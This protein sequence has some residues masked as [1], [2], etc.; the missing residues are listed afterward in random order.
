MPSQ[1]PSNSQRP[2]SGPSLIPSEAPSL[3]PSQSAAPSEA[4]Q[5]S[6]SP[7]I[8][9]EPSAVPTGSPV[10]SLHLEGAVEL[11]DTDL[12]TLT[13]EETALFVELFE[14]AI[15]SFANSASDDVIEST[16][17][18]TSIEGIGDRRRRN[19]QGSDED[20][21]T[22]N[23]SLD[24][25]TTCTSGCLDNGDATK[26]AVDGSVSDGIEDALVDEIL[27]ASTSD[28]VNNALSLTTAFAASIEAEESPSTAD[29]ESDNGPT[30]ETEQEQDEAPSASVAESDNGLSIE[31]QEQVEISINESTDTALAAEFY[32]D[33]IGHSGTCRNDG[34][35]P[36]YMTL[37]QG[38]IESS[39]QDCC[40][41]HF[42]FDMA[43]C[44]G[45]SADVFDR[46]FPDW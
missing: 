36:L 21:V 35:A 8:S 13:Q 32:P 30:I 14:G 5:P 9:F 31:T 26:L 4:N 20:L 38:W 17:T 44:L 2:S 1:Q 45:D 3:E 28:Q 10:L 34:N 39:L 15:E 25:A 24:V 43:S 27:D 42:K 7:S 6:S 23:Y 40:S 33:W 37:N 46:W 22:I 29:E 16:A 11:S 18:V 41:R 19:L 12:S